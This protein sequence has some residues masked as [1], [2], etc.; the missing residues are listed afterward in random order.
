M[1][2]RE[3]QQDGTTV[4]KGQLPWL[5]ESSRPPWHGTGNEPLVESSPKGL[6]AGAK[7]SHG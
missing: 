4:F 1:A 5:E 6:V 7:L 3:S 2:G